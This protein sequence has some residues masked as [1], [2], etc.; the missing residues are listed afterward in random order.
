MSAVA[1]R[2]RGDAFQPWKLEANHRLGAYIML[3]WTFAA[4]TGHAWD[5]LTFP[6]AIMLV[7]GASSG[8]SEP[9]GAYL[10]NRKMD[11]NQLEWWQFGWLKS[12]P[13][14]AIAFRGAMWGL[15]V[16]VLMHFDHSLIWVLPAYTIA[17]P[18]SAMLSR[19]FLK[20]DW[21]HMEFLRGGL[22]GAI[23]VSFTLL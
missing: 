23:F 21:A 4:L 17:M 5:M 16:S 3:G 22:A 19:R 10:T 12:N 14:L 9:I 18:L 15:P 2:I 11:I 20:S 6:I 13:L 8:L 1:D 7:A